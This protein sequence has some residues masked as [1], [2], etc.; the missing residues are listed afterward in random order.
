MERWGEELSIK[1]NSRLW[2]HHKPSDK[3]TSSLAMF[4]DSREVCKFVETREEPKGL[5]QSTEIVNNI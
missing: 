4:D 3:I 5:E 2:R 1:T